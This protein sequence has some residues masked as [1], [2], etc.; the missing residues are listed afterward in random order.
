VVKTADAKTI[1]YL[2][3]ESSCRAQ[4]PGNFPQYQAGVV[5]GKL[6][7]NTVGNNLIEAPAREG[8]IAAIRNH[9][10]RLYSHLL[11]YVPGRTNFFQ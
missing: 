2:Y 5:F 7:Q 8:Q 3:Q 4:R 9:I 10:M 1:W 11:R 6:L